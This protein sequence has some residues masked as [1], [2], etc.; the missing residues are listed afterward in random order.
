MAKAQ[1]EL[2]LQDSFAEKHVGALICHFEAMTKHFQREEWENCI[3]KSGKFVEAV[4]KALIVASAQPLAKG[5]DFKADKAI[6]TLNNLTAGSVHDTIRITIPRACRFVYEIASN[7]GGRHDPD[8]IDPNIMDANVV[9]GN[10]AW[11]VA[12]M[13]RHAQHGAVDTASAKKIVDS[14]VNRKYPVIEE[15]DGRT[16]FHL[17]GASAPDIALVAL[18]YRYPGRIASGELIKLLKRHHFTEKNARTALQRISKYVDEDD[19]EQL[20]LL[21]PG[22]KKAEEVMSTHGSQK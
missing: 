9:M 5:K 14:L 19:N 16:Y 7:R 4:L 6:N 12:E 10:C 17:N 15:V 11:V 13:I 22:I 3:A 18:N 2:L 8:E 21:A 1:A 20:R